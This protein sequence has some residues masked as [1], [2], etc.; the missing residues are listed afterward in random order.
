M[1][2]CVLE[3]LPARHGSPGQLAPLL[4]LT[5]C[6]SWVLAAGTEDGWI[7]CCSSSYGD[8]YLE[9][10]RGHLGPV[11]ALQVGRASASMARPLHGRPHSMSCAVQCV[12]ARH[13][14]ACEAGH[15]LVQVDSSAL[16]AAAP[17]PPCPPAHQCSCT[18][19]YPASTT[20]TLPPP[21]GVPLP[22]R[23]VH[24]LW[25]RLDCAA[26]AAGPPHPAAHLPDSQRGGAR[27]AVGGQ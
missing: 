12:Q 17:L 7:H 2:W 8:Q 11:Y 4:Y 27:R 25:R 1:M 21:P 20:T 16:P 15:A 5:G 13:E 3:L 19:Q 10:Y 24:Q 6:L 23:L 22:R 9:S 26:V 14:G 18:D